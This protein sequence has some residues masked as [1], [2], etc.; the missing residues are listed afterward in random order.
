MNTT[1]INLS[2]Y[3]NGDLFTIQCIVDTCLSDIV[4]QLFHEDQLLE[5]TTQ[6]VTRNGFV[7]T[8]RLRA[9][10]LLVG[11][12]LCQAVNHLHNK[13][14]QQNFSIYGELE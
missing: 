2:C 14:S 1:D 7:L 5:P 8:A 11:Q 3:A 9:S 13:F 10:D 4:I 12:Y 6:D